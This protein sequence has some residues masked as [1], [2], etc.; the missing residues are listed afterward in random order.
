LGGAGV[1]LR[2]PENVSRGLPAPASGPLRHQF[3]SGRF[4][5]QGL[6]RSYLV[7]LV[8]FDKLF[9]IVEDSGFYWLSMNKVPN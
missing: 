4:Q 8:A 7:K 5:E 6:G 3:T 1:G 9:Q 2:C